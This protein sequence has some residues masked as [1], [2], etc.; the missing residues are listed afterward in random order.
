MGPK[1]QTDES[2][3]ETE[4]LAAEQ[5]EVAN[6]SQG[7]DEDVSE[8]QPICLFP[9]TFSLSIFCSSHVCGTGESDAN[10][11]EGRRKEAIAHMAEI[12]NEFSKL[13]EK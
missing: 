12:E 2:E 5:E 1:V 13:K 4:A 6:Q 10:E 8:G 9:P 7:E 11:S 3:S